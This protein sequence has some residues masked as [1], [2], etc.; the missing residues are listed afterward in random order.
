MEKDIPMIIAE[1]ERT[2]L[3]VDKKD[4]KQII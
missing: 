4:W 3:K 1:G 2:L